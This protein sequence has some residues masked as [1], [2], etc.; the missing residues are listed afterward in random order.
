ML[1]PEYLSDVTDA[2]EEKTSELNIYLLHKLAQSLQ[3]IFE[4][5]GEVYFMPKHI[6]DMRKLKNAGM[7]YKEIEKEIT[8][9]LPWL[10][11]EVKDMFQS[12]AKEIEKGNDEFMRDVVSDAK[13]EGYTAGT[14]GTDLPEE[15]QLYGLSAKEMR[16]MEYAY[17]KTLGTIENITGTTAKTANNAFVDA[18]D[19]AWW[20]MSAGVDPNTAIVDALKELGKIGVTAVSYGNREDKVEVALARAV[21]TGISQANGDIAL[22]RCAEIGADYVQVSQHLGARVTDKNDFTNH[23]WWQGKVYSIDWNNPALAKYKPTRKEREKEKRTES[24]DEIKKILSKKQADFPDFIKCCGYGHIQGIC[25]IN[26]RHNFSPF[27]PGHNENNNVPID[28]AENKRIYDL[29]QKQRAMERKIREL[30]RVVETLKN[31]GNKSDECK[32]AIKNAKAKLREKALEYE[33]FCKTNHLSR[34]NWRLKI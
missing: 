6:Y 11:K 12:A 28:P 14:A 32:D 20:K 9:Q 30:K 23:S 2:T 18:C 1:T 21:R 29:S 19:R 5:D 27:Y 26:C 7:L 24:Y 25:G 33:D 3:A 15:V 8:K 22:T 31:S 10:K 16:L 13:K 17:A 34:A 4:R